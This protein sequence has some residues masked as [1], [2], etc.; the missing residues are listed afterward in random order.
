LKEESF[1]EVTVSDRCSVGFLEEG[2]GTVDVK[3]GPVMSEPPTFGMIKK[4]RRTTSRSPLWKSCLGHCVLKIRDQDQWEK[5]AYCR[6]WSQGESSLNGA[7]TCSEGKG[8]Y[9][10][11]TSRGQGRRRAASGLRLGRKTEQ[12]RNKEKTCRINKRIGKKRG[13]A[14]RVCGSREFERIWGG[15]SSL[16]GSAWGERPPGSIYFPR[17]NDSA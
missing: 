6:N 1:W 14:R 16:W 17:E 8:W 15:G 12:R 3:E 5:E 4:S 13:G 7:R 9:L 10:G 2:W 11:I